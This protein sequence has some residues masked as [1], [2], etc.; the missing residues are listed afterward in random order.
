VD[1]R[2]ALTAVAIASAVAVAAVLGF[3]WLHSKGAFQSGGESIDPP[4]FRERSFNRHLWRTTDPYVPG[5]RYD[6]RGT[7]LDDLIHTLR[8][9]WTLPAATSLLGPADQRWNRTLF[10]L[11]GGYHRLDESCLGLRVNSERRIVSVAI[12]D[13]TSE[14]SLPKGEVNELCRHGVPLSAQAR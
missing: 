1:V 5:G 6:L 8:P 3:L 14:P 12:I 4:P 9:G 2:P 7:M 11:T 10:W 13:M